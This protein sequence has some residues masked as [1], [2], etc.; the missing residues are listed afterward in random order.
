[1]NRLVPDFRRI[2]VPLQEG[3]VPPHPSPVAHR[4]LLTCIGFA[5]NRLNFG[6]RFAG[7][8][9]TDVIERF[10]GSG[11]ALRVASQDGHKENR[12]SMRH[13]TFHSSFLSSR[14][15]T[16]ETTARRSARSTAQT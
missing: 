14:K 4:E 12:Q 10:V 9:V 2:V 13:L 11:A 6:S 1:M 5:E 15:W 7:D 3:V 16:G 8:E